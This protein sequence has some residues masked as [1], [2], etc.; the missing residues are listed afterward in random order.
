MHLCGANAILAKLVCV[1]VR[2]RLS[3]ARVVL[4]ARRCL[5]YLTIEHRGELPDGLR[6]SGRI[7]GCDICRDV[8]PYGCSEVPVNV[9]PELQPRQS[10]LD[11]TLADIKALDQPSFSRIFSHSAVKR[12]KLAGLL[13][14]ASRK[15]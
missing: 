2:G 1:P 4:D 11:L 7:Y 6:L 15:E 14:N 3:T 10:L 13:R 9:L 12:A 5:S 8:C